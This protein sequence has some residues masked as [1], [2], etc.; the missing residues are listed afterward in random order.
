MAGKCSGDEGARRARG[1]SVAVALLVPLGIV[2][3][4]AADFAG[5][6][7]I[8]DADGGIRLSLRMSSRSCKPRGGVP[9]RHDQAALDALRPAWAVRGNPNGGPV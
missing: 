5:E 1:V 6:V 7:E 4:A 3:A 9:R 8:R 2:A